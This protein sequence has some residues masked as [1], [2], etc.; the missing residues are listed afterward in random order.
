MER[1]WFDGDAQWAP[2]GTLSGGER[3]RLQLLLTLVAQPNVL[4]LDEPTNDLDLDT[5]RALEDFFEDWPGS[6][7]VVSHDRAFLDRTVEDVLAV[8]AL[9][10]PSLVRGGVAGWLA[11]RAESS[12]GSSG[13]TPRAEPRA[14]A[15]ARMSAGCGRRRARHTA[16]PRLAESAERHVAAQPEHVASAPRQR[17]TRPGHGGGTP[18]RG[19]RRTVGCRQRPHRARPPRRGGGGRRRG[20]RQ[21]RGT[22]VGVGRR[23]GVSR[24][25]DVAGRSHSPHSS[26]MSAVT[27]P[28]MP[29]EPSAWVRMWQCHAQTPGSTAV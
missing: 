17:R 20:T 14:V 9:D 8:D 15:L 19:D 27:I 6:L 4:L 29:C 18:G 25:H 11:L 7:V 21:C 23:S 5:L 10:R 12:R 16:G 22:M 1:F 13:S 3:R 26:T 2:I 24:P 28:N